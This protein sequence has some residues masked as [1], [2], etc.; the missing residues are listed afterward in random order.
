MSILSLLPFA[1]GFMLQLVMDFMHPLIPP[2]S[3]FPVIEAV[4]V[5][6]R[7]PLRW[8]RLGILIV[9]C[10]FIFILMVLTYVYGGYEGWISDKPCVN[11]KW[12]WDESIKLSHN[13]TQAPSNK[14]ATSAMYEY[15]GCDLDN[16]EYGLWL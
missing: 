1:I 16:V 4:Y 2:R 8:I 6:K 3:Y 14:T 11:C 13:Q 12:K 10:V 5:P 7:M 15:Y 9:Y